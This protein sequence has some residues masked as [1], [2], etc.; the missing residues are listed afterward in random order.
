MIIIPSGRPKIW[1]KEPEIGAI[2]AENAYIGTFHNL[3]K[4]YAKSM[5][6]PYLILSPKFGFL[7]PADL[8]AH[9]YDVRFTHK[10][11]DSS[12]ISLEALR[13]QWLILN[14][15]YSNCITVLG[16]QKF[17]PLLNA[18][19]FDTNHTFIFPLHGLGGI[20]HM[21][22]ALKEAIEKGVPLG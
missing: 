8:V 7:K 4:S 1:D 17:K 9:S 13:K 14:L 2:P 18:I 20:G 11:T 15:P 16:G 12:T 19:A 22:G 5:N 21:Q 6:E 10:G 3:C